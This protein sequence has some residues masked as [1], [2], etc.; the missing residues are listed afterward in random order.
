MNNDK[1][2]RDWTEET[3]VIDFTNS[4]GETYH[5]EIEPNAD[6]NII[7]FRPSD[8]PALGRNVSRASNRERTL[9]W[10]H[11]PLPKQLDMFEGVA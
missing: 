8:S 7:P 11:I 1:C 3:L 5:F 6:P 4:L 9:V 10:L 2:I